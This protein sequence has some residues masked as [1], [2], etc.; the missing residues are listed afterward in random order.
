MPKETTTAS[1]QLREL[2]KLI[3]KIV[4]HSLKDNTLDHVVQISLSSQEPEQV[5]YSAQISSPAKGVQPITFVFDNFN[6]LK[7]SLEASV[8]E[9]NR[10]D[11]E[12]AFHENMLNTLKNRIEA[13]EKRIEE[14][15]N[16]EFEV[17]DIPMEEV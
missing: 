16:G 7:A 13:H 9:I 4:R 17:D 15:K 8:K 1:E 2:E 6:D 14:I 11:V 10:E 5:K 3:K 12:L